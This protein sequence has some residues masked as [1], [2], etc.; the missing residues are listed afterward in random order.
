MD[1]EGCEYTVLRDL[2]VDILNRIENIIL[3][4]H[5][6]LK[7]LPDILRKS[8]FNVD[9]EDKPI[10]ILKVYKNDKLIIQFS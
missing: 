10:W 2:L 3:E 1:C 4:S 9:Y 7:D 6:Y 8:G 5:D